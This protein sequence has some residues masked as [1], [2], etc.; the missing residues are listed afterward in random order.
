[1]HLEPLL[2]VNS[3]AAMPLNIL[4]SETV[5]IIFNCNCGEFNMQ[6]AIPAVIYYTDC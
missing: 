6:K 5:M 2:Y 4:L 1:M 3:P